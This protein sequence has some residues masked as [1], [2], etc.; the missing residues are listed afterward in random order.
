MAGEESS[1]LLLS[2]LVWALCSLTGRLFTS[3]LFRARGPRGPGLGPPLAPRLS[4]LGAVVVSGERSPFLEFHTSPGSLIVSP[5]LFSLW[6]A[7]LFCFECRFSKLDVLTLWGC[8]C[9]CNHI[10][11]CHR[12]LFGL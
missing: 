9:L 10:F 6:C 12:V 1:S 7:F 8:F 4:A 11:D 2:P 5:V 3:G